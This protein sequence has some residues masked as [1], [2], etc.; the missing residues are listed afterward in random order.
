MNVYGLLKYHYPLSITH[1][2]KS[3]MWFFKNLKHANY[4]SDI[5]KRDTVV[6]LDIKEKVIK[7][8][9]SFL[10]KDPLCDK[11]NTFELYPYVDIHI[12][13]TKSSFSDFI[14]VDELDYDTYLSYPISKIPSILTTHIISESED[15]IIFG[16]SIS[17]S[18]Q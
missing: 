18:M 10:M 13:K 1:N 12:T 7:L 17:E 2:N 4:V 6:S 5:L 11:K 3:Y 9:V 15:K 14:D 8:P 16:A